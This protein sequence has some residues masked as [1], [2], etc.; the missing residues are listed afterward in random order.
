MSGRGRWIG[1][2]NPVD[3]A[4]SQGAG[5]VRRLWVDRKRDDRR[6]RTLVEQAEAA[7]I[8]VEK[9][10]AKALGR[11]LPEV[12][13]Q[14]V[15]AEV[16]DGDTLDESA[17]LDR[18]QGLGHEALIVAL[19]GVQD[20]HNLGA[21]IR[22]A[23]AAGADALIVPRD[24]AAGLTPTVERTAAGAAQWLPVAAVNNLARTLG[25]L[26]ELGLWVVGTAG[27]APQTL[28]SAD[29][30]GPVVLVLGGEEKGMR[31]GVRQRCDLV[32]H[33]PLMGRTDSLNVSVA[34]GVC[35]FEALR[36]RTGAPAPLGQS[37]GGG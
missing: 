13:H 1:G 18:L 16:V 15:A 35:L 9:V 33:I 30:R 21:C 7:G 8:A 17:L 22:S 34:T 27:D 5:R 24:G 14:G 25:E 23:E 2:F 4:V 28:W 32:V 12:R 3:A 10:T 6:L 37:S 29:L 26:R 11:H 20:P 36:Q 31:P 19:D